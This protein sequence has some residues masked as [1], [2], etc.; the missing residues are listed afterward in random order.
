[1]ECGLD[2]EK[3]VGSQM[4]NDKVKQRNA[5][6]DIIEPLTVPV[7]CSSGD[8]INEKMKT[9]SIIRPRR[10]SVPI[11]DVSRKLFQD[12]SLKFTQYVYFIYKF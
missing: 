7:K 3:M 12:D 2:E 9:D 10:Q 6:V 1:M 8:N 5:N 4:D 11:T